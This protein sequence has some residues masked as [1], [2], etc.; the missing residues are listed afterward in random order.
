MWKQIPSICPYS[1]FIDLWK[2]NT[3]ACRLTST[4]FFL[5]I[6]RAIVRVKGEGKAG[7]KG[8]ING[9]LPAGGYD[10]GISMGFYYIGSIA[11]P[12]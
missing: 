10:G 9:R 4:D 1:A 5:Y 8:Y 7:F 2:G 11:A 6:Q 12:K 3:F